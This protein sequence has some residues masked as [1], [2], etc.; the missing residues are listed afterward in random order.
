MARTGAGI[1][2]DRITVLRPSKVQN[3]RGGMTDTIKTVT[4]DLPARI[5][6]K[7]GSEE[8]QSQRLSGV[9]PYEITVRYDAASATI[10][11]TDTLTDQNGKRYAI[12]WAGSLDEGRPRWITISAET[13][14]VSGR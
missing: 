3:G 10:A 6:V 1:L 12:K 5:V 7:R 11:A 13:G 14:T 9:T 2:R 8:V 4:T